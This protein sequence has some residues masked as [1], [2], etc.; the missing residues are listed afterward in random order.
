MTTELNEKSNKGESQ[1]KDGALERLFHL[2]ENNTTK[3]VELFAGLTTFLSMAYILAVNPSLLGQAGMPPSGVFVATV[4]AA[5]IGTAVM[6]FMA[7]YP[8]VLA[9][10]MGLNAYFAFSIVLGM[11]YSWQ[12]A[13]FAVFLEGL[14]FIA[15]TLARAREKVVDAIP[16]S[17]KIGVGSGIGVFLAYIGLQ[18][19]H[20]IVHSDST[21]TTFLS[22]DSSTIHTSGAAVILAIIGIV[23]ITVL[24]HKKIFGA[25]F[26][27]MIGT[28]GF[29]VIAQLIGLYQPDPANGFYSVI[30]SFDL[31]AQTQELK[32][33]FKEVCFAAFNVNAWTGKGGETGWELLFSINILL[34]LFAL[35][36]VDFFDTIGTVIAVATK[37]NMYDEKG[38]I[39][40]IK[41][42]LFADAF[43]TACG[44][45]LGTSTTTTYIESYTGIAV[46]G[47]TGLTALTAAFLFLISLL[48]APVFLALP[49][50]V[51]GAALIY[52]G[53]LMI[54][55]LSK[56]NFDDVSEAAPAFI[57]TIVIP[58]AYS[59]SEGIAISFILWTVINL[60]SGQRQK[61]SPLM[62]V[63]SVLFAAK[64]FFI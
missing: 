61:I 24:S 2:R 60:V 29:S 64:Y 31:N 50:F 59:I 37:E 32:N 9:P 40:R 58:L 54:T 49:S 22:F 56:L 3:R 62:Y 53:F 14:I 23:L 28:W 8:L 27:G 5:F 52:V 42:I 17:L 38:K 47:R 12:F 15:L 13:L 10:G 21:L 6:A 25:L 63:L 51:S 39:P 44:G 30:P 1:T 35:L 20:I 36:F 41:S 46:G 45:A 55:P 33:G 48:F 18:N 19:A 11:G 57:A 34:V 43:A 26:W 16:Q 7:N 4:S